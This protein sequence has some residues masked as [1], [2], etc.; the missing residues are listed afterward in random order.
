MVH[1]ERRWPIKPI[2][3]YCM[4]VYMMTRGIRKSRI[5]ILNRFFD[6]V[7]AYLNLNCP[8]TLN[9]DI[10]KSKLILNSIHVSRSVLLWNKMEVIIFCWP[11]VHLN[12]SYRSY[13]TP[14]HPRH[15]VKRRLNSNDSR[16]VQVSAWINQVELWLLVLLI[17]LGRKKD[18]WVVS[19]AIK[20]CC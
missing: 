10:R 11:E 19:R 14:S 5:N 18:K 8:S 7:F 16:L 15:D 17:H 6:F 4:W 3:L 9:V 1:V 20:C 12:G 2:F 13:V